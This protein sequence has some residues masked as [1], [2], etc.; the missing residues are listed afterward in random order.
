MMME[1]A[2]KIAPDED[3][4]LLEI[5]EN[6]RDIS[7]EAME[8]SREYVHAIKSAYNSTSIHYFKRL[9]RIEEAFSRSQVKVIMNL[10]NA[11]HQYTDAIESFIVR[12]VMEGIT[13]AIR[14]GK[15]DKIEISL[16][17]GSESLSISVQ[18]NGAGADSLL[19]G[20]GLIG[21]ENRLD[22]IRGQIEYKNLDWGFLLRVK[23]P[24]FVEDL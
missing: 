3:K 5:L 13:N 6:T 24:W 15:A 18:D 9:K 16:F 23:I 22:K 8:K 11:H 1:A 21:I 12:M 20:L 19:P 7:R 2:I 10:G 17:Q 4:Q 14:H